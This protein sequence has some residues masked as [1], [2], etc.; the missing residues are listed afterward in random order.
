MSGVELVEVRAE[1]AD[2][3]LDRWLRRRVPGLTQGRIEK[4]L[5]KGEIRLDGKRADG[6]TRVY[7]GQVVRLPPNIEKLAVA[8]SG[9]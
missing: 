6:K 8:T 5:R 4:L 1:D 9:L 3:R 7:A 2:Q